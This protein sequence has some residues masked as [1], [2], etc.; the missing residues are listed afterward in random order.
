MSRSWAA[1]S[2]YFESIGS[3]RSLMTGKLF[4]PIATVC[5]LAAP[6]FA[7][8]TMSV[9][10]QGV[11]GGNWVWDVQIT[12]DLSLTSDGTSP[13]AVDLGFRLTGDPLVSVTNVNPSI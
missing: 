11:I 7:A 3:R 6:L 5:A 8:P 2:L 13:L 10:P 12:P 4:A 1:A 9:L